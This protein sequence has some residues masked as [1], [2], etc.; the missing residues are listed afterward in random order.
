MANFGM[1][2]CWQ[3]RLHFQAIFY[4]RLA[5]LFYLCQIRNL[6]RM[7][8][9]TIF[10]LLLSSLGL[11]AQTPEPKETHVG[12]VHW[13][14][15][16]EAVERNKKEKKQIFIDVYTTWCGPCKMMDKHTFADPAVAEILNKNFYPVKLNAEQKEDISFMGTVFKFVPSGASGYHQLAAG[17][18]SN[19]LQYPSFVFMTE[20]H[21]IMQ[22]IS[23]FHQPPD[24]HRIIQFIGEGHFKKMNWEEWQSVY[25]SPYT[26]SSSGPGK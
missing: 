17:L 1:D 8:S 3:T 12:P 24:F 10:I 19:K 20:D 13:L 15:F 6:T 16:E 11:F 14:S 5:I 26:S 7:K 22:A 25:K 18:L 2:S 9:S 4:P 21:K 23:G